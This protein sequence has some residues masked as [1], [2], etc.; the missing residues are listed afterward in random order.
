[1]SFPVWNRAQGEHAAAIAGEHRATQTRE[2][3]LRAAER[4]V[5]DALAAYASAQQAVDTFEREVAPLLDDSDQLLQKTVDAGQIAVHDYLVARQEL[6]AG[7]R[8]YLERL[9]A[10]AKAAAGVRFAAGVTP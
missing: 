5:A 1:M 9:L 8:E 10:L 6:V 3:T 2:A 7:R 4:Q